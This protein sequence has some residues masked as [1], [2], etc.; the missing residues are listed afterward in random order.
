[1]LN[2]DEVMSLYEN[3]SRLTGAMLQAAKQQDWEQL[4]SLETQCS[5]EINVLKVNGPAAPL[6]GALRIRKIE[7]LEKILSDDKAIR[8]A[9]QPWMTEL[10]ALIR[11]TGTRRKLEQGYS[12]RN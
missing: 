8:D 1:M 3:V 7:I 6:M 11:N 2:N 12:A 9:T 4:N 10:Q 5:H